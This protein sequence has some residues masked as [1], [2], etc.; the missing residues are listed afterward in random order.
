M[1]EGAGEGADEGADEG[2]GGVAGE[3]R[4]L[5]DVAF[6]LLGTSADAEDAVQETYARWYA[7]A[8]E[9]RAAVLNPQAW[10]TRVVGRVCLDVLGSAR[11]RRERC[12]GQ[13]LPEPVPG[14]GWQGPPDPAER[15]TVDESVRM[16]LLVALD[17]LTP[18]QRVAFVLHEVFALPFEDVA[19]VVGRTPQACRKLASTAR[20]DIREGRRRAAADED[21]REV[22]R[23][24]LRACAAGDLQALV[25][26]LDPGVSAR[27]DGGG[28]VRAAP[29][30]VV[31]AERVA[32]YLL[33]A[34]AKWS[35]V[36]LVDAEVGGLPGVV[37][38]EAGAVTGVAGFDVRD[39]RVSA[40]WLVRAPGKLRLWG[41][42]GPGPGS[43][44]AARGGR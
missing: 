17:A 16:A 37:L 11:V 19:E 18:A 9:E 12:V 6:R 33:G 31:G 7:L 39:G 10:L 35:H 1:S 26:L 30:A 34:L 20:R 4:H 23:A 25:L 22:V 14:A 21:H 43:S 24:F 3:R 28:R 5:L 13:W 36:E 44:A 42:A 8:E 29:N 40:V 32:R 41:G 27:T 15:I 2:A 38:R